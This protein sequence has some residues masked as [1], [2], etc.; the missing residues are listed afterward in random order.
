MKTFNTGYGFIDEKIK[1]IKNNLPENLVNELNFILIKT[2]SLGLHE[3]YTEGVKSPQQQ[4]Q[5]NS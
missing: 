4:T 1:E 3:G 5:V 2:H